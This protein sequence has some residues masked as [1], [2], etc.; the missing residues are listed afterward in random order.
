[1]SKRNST[2]LHRHAILN[3]IFYSIL[4]HNL[5]KKFDLLRFIYYANYICFTHWH[6]SIPVNHKTWEL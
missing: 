1:M 5:T 6:R 2:I 4:Q 3:K